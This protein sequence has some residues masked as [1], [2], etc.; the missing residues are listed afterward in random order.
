MFVRFLKA[1]PIIPKFY[2][3]PTSDPEIVK[4][5]SGSGLSN[6]HLCVKLQSDRYSR[7]ARKSV[8]CTYKHAATHFYT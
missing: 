8:H 7:L 3:L 1:A 5:G 4:A 2:T 6:P